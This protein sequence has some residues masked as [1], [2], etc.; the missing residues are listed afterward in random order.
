MIERAKGILM[1]QTGLDEPAAFGRLQ[2]LA[3]EKNKKLLEIA[4]AI[5]AW[6][7]ASAPQDE[8]RS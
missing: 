8:S 6:E 5:L 3:S 4:Q 2:K 1:R 7:E